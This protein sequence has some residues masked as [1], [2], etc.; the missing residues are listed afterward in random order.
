[1]RF[2]GPGQT[3]TLKGVS[4]NR[5]T[6]QGGSTYTLSP[7]GEWFVRTGKY[8]SLQQYDPVTGT[9]QT[10][11]G[12]SSGSGGFGGVEYVYSDGVNYR[13][14][15]QTGCAVGAILTTAGSG[16]TTA[17]TVTASAG[18]SIWKAIVG[19]AVNTSVTVV[20]GGS[21]Y[22][23]PPTVVFSNPP[24]GGGIQATGYSTISSGAVSSVTI[25]NQ[26]AGYT[27]APTIT[28]I[29][30]PRE[31]PN[32]ATGATTVT[33]GSGA[34]A[35]CTLTG[36]Q[37]VTGLLCLDHGTS[38]TAV[39]TLSFGSGT[40]A[41][42]AIMC[43]TVTAATPSTPGA[44]LAGTFAQITAED[45]FAALTASAYTNPST[46]GNLVTIRPA[47]IIGTVTSNAL[48]TPVTVYDGGIY[49]ATPAALVIPTASVVT[50]A[51][52]ATLTMGSAVDTSY[53]MQL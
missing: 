20:N 32:I 53:V 50:T 9:W 22:T 5:V 6:L 15:N 11:G 16:Y 25:T 36:S 30:D 4:W 23:Y 24:L 2:A 49:T 46:Q 37:T 42:L 45:R 41:A 51:P 44:G 35:V 14:A 27:G 7:A 39:P 3:P 52:A 34:S 19:G 33:Y 43:W 38:L 13:L 31:N 48:A 18:S 26:G 29:N 10:I 28:F 47:N 1:M 12:G 8:T 40:A 21:N 17:P